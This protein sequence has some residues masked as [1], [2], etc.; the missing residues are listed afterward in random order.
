M[1][2]ITCFV[3]HNI[4]GFAKST[5]KMFIF[6]RTLVDATVKACTLIK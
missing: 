6:I 5:K 3:E 4:N 1:R 2:T